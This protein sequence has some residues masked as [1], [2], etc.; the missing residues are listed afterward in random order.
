MEKNLIGPKELAGYLD[1]S[2]NTIY[3]WVNMRKIPFFKIG[4]L[5]KFDLKEIDNWKASRKVEVSDLIREE[6]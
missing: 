5:V 6:L 2:I 3:S 4:R 1:I